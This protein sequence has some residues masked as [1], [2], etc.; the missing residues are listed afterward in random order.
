M[1]DIHYIRENKT[2]VKAN[3]KRRKIDP[4]KA[5]IDAILKHDKMRREVQ[6]DLEK[7]NHERKL[8]AKG[9]LFDKGRELKAKGQ[10]L[11]TKIRA[12]DKLIF[13]Y[14]QWVP[15]I[16]HKSVPDGDSEKDNK[17]IKKV[18]KPPTFSYQAQ[19]H[20][21][22]GESL[23]ILDIKRGAKVTG[24]GFYYW[25]GDGAKLAWAVYN[26]ALTYFQ[27][28]N[29]VPVIVPLITREAAI[30]GTGYFPFFKEDSY[31]LEGKDQYLIG[32]SEQALVAIHQNEILDEAN[33]PYQYTSF[34]AG[35]REEA[36]SYGKNTK[37][38]YRVHQFH[39]VEQ[40]VFCKPEN[41][42]TWHKTCLKHEE[43]LLKDLELPYQVVD[44]CVGDIGAPGYRKFD[45]EA[46]FPSQNRYREVT[47]NTNLTDFQTRRLNIRA[48]GKEGNKYYPHT[49]S[50]TGV[51]DRFVIAILENNQQK[52]GS[53]KIPKILQKDVGKSV[54]KPPTS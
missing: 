46:W 12:L 43:K 42:E 48:R 49:I 35:F 11:E 34:S 15:N 21:Q 14:A 23:R 13:E 32:T 18:G 37:G 27:K 29:F 30:F 33:L 39:K 10:K 40:I 7:I 25:V 26:L 17:P 45:C 22:L 53:V 41:S 8:A 44:V 38:I 3:I 1:L 31:Q 24:Q 4:T 54:I 47:S 9:R 2:A 20:Q 6:L 19:N 50:A 52:D 36:G 51:T 5:D 28:Q 16:L